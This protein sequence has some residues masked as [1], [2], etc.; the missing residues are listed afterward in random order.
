MR[1]EIAGTVAEAEGHG[2]PLAVQKRAD[3][4]AHLGHQARIVA[5][6]QN[7]VRDPVSL[8]SGPDA[9][10]RLVDEPRRAYHRLRV[11]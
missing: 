6:R 11:R 10:D 2:Q 8:R 5:C 4:V 7:R 1:I 3:H 9:P